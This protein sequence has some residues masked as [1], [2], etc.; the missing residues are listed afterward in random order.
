M[1][2][3]YNVLM[4]HF[5]TLIKKMILLFCDIH[6]MCVLTIEILGHLDIFWCSVPR[7]ANAATCA[8]ARTR[9]VG[10]SRTLQLTA[11]SPI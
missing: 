7:V 9:G 1:I 6:I 11:T 3:L 8:R 10:L 4:Y 5:K 2:G